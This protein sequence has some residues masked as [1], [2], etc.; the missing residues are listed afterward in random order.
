MSI[1]VTSNRDGTY[2][3]TCGNESTIIGSPP[4]ASGYPKLSN[5]PHGVAAHIINASGKST[6]GKRV[7]SGQDIVFDLAQQASGKA[8]KGTSSQ[9]FEYTLRGAQ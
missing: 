4:P 9:I 2:T 7:R 5:P 6:R 3:V 1:V 8:I